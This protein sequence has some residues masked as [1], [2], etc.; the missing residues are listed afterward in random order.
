MIPIGYL[1]FGYECERAL[2]FKALADKLDLP[3]SLHK[4]RTRN[5]T[6]DFMYWNEY[7]EK[8]IIDLMVNVGDLLEVGH[9]KSFEYCSMIY[10]R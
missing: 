3:V 8:Y 5:I 9:P 7:N 1:R 4:N 10:K 6:R 2:L